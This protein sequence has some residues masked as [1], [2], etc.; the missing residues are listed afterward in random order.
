MI[1]SFLT[2]G[3]QVL[4]LFLLMSVGFILGKAKVIDDRVSKGMS[5]LVLLVVSP[6]MQIVSFQRP[7]EVALLRN[8]GV[9][10]VLALVILFLSMTLSH[11]LIPKNTPDK[12]ILCF[13][14]VFSNAGFMG[15]PM[16]MALLGSIGV[17]YGT[18][19]VVAF[20]ILLWTYGAWCMTGDRKQLRLRPILTNPGII[21]VIIGMALYLLQI[22]LPDILLTP[23]TYLS[24]LNT[25]LPMI[26]VGYQ[27]SQADFRTV[28]RHRGVPLAV[29]LRLLVVPLLIAG[30]F[31]A[32]HLDHE[33]AVALAVAASAPA[34]A[35][36]SMF[37]A[38][39]NQNTSLASGV[40]SLETL[41]SV[42]TMPLIVGLITYLL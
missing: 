23:V 39:F 34:A 31:L 12:P 28:V 21:G 9:C 36:T 25:P 18:A 19:Y 42:I 8:Y 17:F 1:S 41:L 5:N 29:V 14:T 26:V 20:Y 2:V 3:E 30:L 40:V 11:S 32:L 6:C 13:A 37:S 27:L 7:L 35:A 22:T 16:Q 4:I 24:Q 33:I 38:R 15:Y 10:L